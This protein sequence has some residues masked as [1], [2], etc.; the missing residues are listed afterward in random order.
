MS[1][2]I[3]DMPV[4]VCPQ[5]GAV[6]IEDSIM[7]EDPERCPRCGVYPRPVA[8]GLGDDDLGWV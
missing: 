1:G 3:D 2:T 5:C 7:Y 6:W 4:R 8:E